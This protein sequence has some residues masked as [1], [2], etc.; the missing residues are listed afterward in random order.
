M[1]STTR[2]KALCGVLVALVIYQ[3]RASEVARDA[4]PAEPEPV[5]KATTG[6]A[7]RASRTRAG[8]VRRSR[9]ELVR[10]LYAARGIVEI[11]LLAEQ[12]GEV[13]DDATIDAILPLVLD[14][15]KGVAEAILGAI[16]T[17]GT[18]HAVDV[19][20]ARTRHGTEEVRDA[21]VLA[22]ARSPHR[23]AEDLLVE[24]AL[25]RDHSL[26]AT[27]TTALG[28]LGSDRAVQTLVAIA[29]SADDDRSDTAIEAIARIGSAQALDALARLVDSPDPEVAALA[30]EAITV[31]DGPLFDKLRGL[32]ASSDHR[33]LVPAIAA[34]GRAGERALP[35]LRELALGEHDT[36]V[37]AAAVHALARSGPAGA[38][39]T[40]RAIVDAEPDAMTEIAADVLAV[41]PGDES[42]DLLISIA[43]STTEASTRAIEHLAARRDDDADRALLALADADPDMSDTVLHE[44]ISHGN[45]A[46]LDRAVRNLHGT[47]DSG[48][49]IATIQLLAETGSTAARDTL[50]SLARGGDAE[51]R[52][53]VLR[54]LA[55]ARP[56]DPEVFQLAR[57]AMRASSPD[58]VNTALAIVADARSPEARN[59]LAGVLHHPDERVVLSAV[60]AL[61]ALRLDEQTLDTLRAAADQHPWLAPRVTVKLLAEGS[62]LGLPLAEAVLRDPDSHLAAGVRYH[63]RVAANSLPEATALLERYPPSEPEIVVDWE[64]LV[65]RN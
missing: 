23:R 49:R 65:I 17:I 20:R 57:E 62:A 48:E 47:L 11:E 58:E 33:L 8:G 22:L 60:G 34:L 31:V 19:L 29:G 13:G 21:A 12:L 30:L 52:H 55:A 16:G 44:L 38:V 10:Q 53:D 28:V 32:V 59:L 36:D 3:A 7:A 1:R 40:L 51:T 2:W 56:A 25:Q 18:D 5:A 6:T 14:A 43:L 50:L 42:R 26:A 46:A 61:E 37:R 41:L 27:A 24:L 9:D 54:A 63:L 35:I 39:A 45:R 15:R 64:D 4:T